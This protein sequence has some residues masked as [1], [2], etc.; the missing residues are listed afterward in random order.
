ME[1]VYARGGEPAMIL[2]AAVELETGARGCDPQQL[3]LA[4]NFRRVVRGLKIWTW[5]RVTDPRSAKQDAAKNRL[6]D[7]LKF[8]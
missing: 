4:E 6:A 5:R 8:C 7:I 3:C 2:S 1:K